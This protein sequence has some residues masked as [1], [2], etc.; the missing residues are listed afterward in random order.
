MVEDCKPLADLSPRAF[1]P[2]HA[3]DVAYDGTEAASKP[4][5]NTYDVVVLDRTL[6]GSRATRSA[7]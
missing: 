6:P 2:G 1:G 5:V 3:A 4:R 7:R